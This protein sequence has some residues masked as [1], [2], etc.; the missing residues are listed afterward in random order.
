MESLITGL[1]FRFSLIIWYTPSKFR[2]AKVTCIACEALKKSRETSP[3][4]LQACK[5]RL[6]NALNRFY[7]GMMG[8]QNAL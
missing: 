7:K 1:S 2:N 5:K 6:P 8:W 3:L 4:L